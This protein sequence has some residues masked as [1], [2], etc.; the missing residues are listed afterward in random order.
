MIT[1]KKDKN[2][3]VIISKLN[4]VVLKEIAKEGQGIYV[5]ASK[6]DLGIGAIY[7]LLKTLIKQQKILGER[8]TRLHYSNGF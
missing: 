5:H 3:K 7:K 4:E 1:N 2:G 6:N 8:H